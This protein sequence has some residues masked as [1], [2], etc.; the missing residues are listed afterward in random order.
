[1][2]YILAALLF[3]LWLGATLASYTLHGMIHIL[4]LV[5]FFMVFFDLITGRKAPL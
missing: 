2:I 3:F 5:V 4:L 1:M